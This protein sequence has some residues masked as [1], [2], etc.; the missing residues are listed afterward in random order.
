MRVTKQLLRS[1]IRQALNEGLKEAGVDY[2]SNYDSIL[3]EQRTRSHMVYL[4]EGPTG[5]GSGITTFGTVMEKFDRGDIDSNQMWNIIETSLEYEWQRMWGDP[6]LTE[7]L[8]GGLGAKAD[9]FLAKSADGPDG[10]SPSPVC[11]V[12]PHEL[13]QH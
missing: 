11:R 3:A 2:R 8:F 1:R 9:E 13:L 5:L 7:G 10:K 12:C 6:L 4:C